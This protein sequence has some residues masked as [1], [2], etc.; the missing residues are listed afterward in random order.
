MRASSRAQ[1]EATK[2]LIKNTTKYKK[3]KK[4]EGRKSVWGDTLSP[5]LSQLPRF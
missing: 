3:Q 1:A 5:Y 2:A 4:N